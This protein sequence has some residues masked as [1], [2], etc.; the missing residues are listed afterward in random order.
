[1]TMYLNY[2]IV[3]VIC[4][5]KLPT[6]LFFYKHSEIYYL[7][8]LVVGLADCSLLCELVIPIGFVMPAAMRKVFRDAQSLIIQTQI[9]GDRRLMSDL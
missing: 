8:E 6:I 2:P 3:C 5:H 4:N 1:M 7:Y 9:H